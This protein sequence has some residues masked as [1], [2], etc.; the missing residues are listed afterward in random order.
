MVA[1]IDESKLFPTLF[2]SGFARPKHCISY[3]KRL[4]IQTPQ[5]NLSTKYAALRDKNCFSY[6]S[7]MKHNL[8]QRHLAD[9]FM[10]NCGKILQLAYRS[11]TTKV[12]K[13]K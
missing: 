9:G 13:K 5:T 11:K 3:Y 1:D 2:A 4:T 6:Q 10:K 7:T 12:C 8:I